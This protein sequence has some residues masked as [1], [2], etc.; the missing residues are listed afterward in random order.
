[1]KI[2]RSPLF[3][4]GDKYKLMS[5]LVELFPK[6][7]NNYYEPFVGGGSSFLN[8]NAKKY[9]VNDI[10]TNII[11]LHKFLS[12]YKD[13]F[14][15]LIKQIEKLII[16]YKLS[17]S[18]LLNTEIPWELKKQ[19][20][21]TYFA[22]YNKEAYL[23]LR[24]D[25]NKN[26][27]KIELLYLLLIFGFNHMIRFNNSQQFNLPVGNVDFNKNVYQALDEYIKFMSAHNVTFENKD[28]LKF[29]KNQKF[30]NNDFIY[31]DPPYLISFSE[32][33]KLWNENKERELYKYLDY[34]NSV[35]VKFGISNITHHKGKENQILLNWMTKYNVYEIK[36]NYIS[37][38][39]NKLKPN[40]REV[41]I[42]NYEK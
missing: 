6:E 39:N 4:V 42:T 23:K 8:V 12:S 10:D 34:L 5:Q 41:Y 31:L 2:K 22:K 20:P 21:K 13:D 24:T 37:R 33:N 19:F 40:L 17:S 30:N 15:K 3:Y 38:F 9:I 35:G 29:L 32:Y 16:H 1:M 27:N 28:Y 25:F 18:F 7:I 26:Q 36:S 11:K 14:S